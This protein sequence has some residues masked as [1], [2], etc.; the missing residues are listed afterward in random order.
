MNMNIS[1]SLMKLF[2]SIPFFF[3]EKKKTNLSQEK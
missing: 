1:L 2:F 3:E